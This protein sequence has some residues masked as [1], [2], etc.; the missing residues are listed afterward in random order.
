MNKI[1]PI[2]I[3]TFNRPEYLS[4]LLDVVQNID[5]SCIYIYRDGPRKDNMKDKIATEQ[6][7]E[8]IE[9]RSFKSPVKTNYSP[10]NNGC[11]YGPYNAISWAFTQEE[12]LIILE[13]DCIPVPIFF[14]F[15]SDML[16]KYRDEPKVRLISG[17]SNMSE[18]P[19]FKRYD[20]IY[21]QY[22]H[23]LG[24]ATWKRVWNGFDIKMLGLREFLRHKKFYSIFSTKEEADFMQKRYRYLLKDKKLCTH[25]WD[26]QFGYYCRREGALGIVPAHNLIKYIGIEGTHP[27][28]IS[29]YLYQINSEQEFS[30]TKC[31]AL[32]KVDRDYDYKYFSKFVYEPQL[33]II[34][35]IINKIKKLCK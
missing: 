33:S 25:S 26:M 6:V 30:Y 20:Y 18:H 34:Q 35:R 1:A 19:I 8:L 10:V 5:S 32:I 3:I 24:W 22:A 7:V 15:C 31:P 21:S 4:R 9:S 14:D 12:E 2:L 11:G 27:S 16:A 28:P 13:D 29:S 17:R 23:T